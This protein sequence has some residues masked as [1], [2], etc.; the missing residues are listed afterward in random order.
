M[1]LIKDRS[2]K[3]SI[4][5]DLEFNSLTMVESMKDHGKM[6]NVKEKDMKCIKLVD[7]TRES[8]LKISLMAKEPIF[9]PM[10]KFTK[11]SG[12]KPGNKASES[13]KELRV[14]AMPVSGK[15]TCKM[16]MEFITGPMVISTKE[17]GDFHSKMG[18][19]L[20]YLPIKTATL[21][22]TQMA[23]LMEKEPISGK[24]AHFT[25]VASSKA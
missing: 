9:G 12:F 20:T 16:D 25:R 1:P 11:V 7:T 8:F 3:I 4:D 17:N 6:I 24:V 19:G 22:S 15:I 2:M 14:T 5:M 23:F 18:K 21:D 13:G 10:G